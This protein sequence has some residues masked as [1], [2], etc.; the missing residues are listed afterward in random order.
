MSDSTHSITPTNG[1]S[2]PALGPRRP[3]TSRVR[4]SLV[5]RRLRRAWRL[6]TDHLRIIE[7]VIVHAIPLPVATYRFKSHVDIAVFLVLSA[8][9]SHGKSGVAARLTI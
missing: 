3:A 9:C 5:L 7:A 1:V 2:T 6:R 4:V 8:T